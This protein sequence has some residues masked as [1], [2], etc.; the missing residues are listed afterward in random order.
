LY[1]ETLAESV[2]ADTHSAAPNCQTC[3]ACCAFFHQ[4]VVLDSD[5]TPRRLTWAVWDDAGVAGPKTR[6]LRRE[7]LAGRCVAFNG[8]VGQHGRCAIYELR[9]MSCRAF[10][11]GSDR[12]RAVRRA[13]R[14]EPPRSTDERIEPSMASGIKWKPLNAATR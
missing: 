8:R 3:G 13:Y 6:W 10:E 2:F 9:P 12:C 7:A 14:L 1:A 4:I 5:P 11:A